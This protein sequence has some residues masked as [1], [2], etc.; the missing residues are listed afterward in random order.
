LPRDWNDGSESDPTMTPQLAL[1][2]N[3]QNWLIAVSAEL[4]DSDHGNICRYSTSEGQ[5][6]SDS[7][8]SIFRL[9]FL[10]IS[11]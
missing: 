7:S 5:F 1:A 4:R 9:S 6:L 2:Q 10:P 3:L 8:K 11:M